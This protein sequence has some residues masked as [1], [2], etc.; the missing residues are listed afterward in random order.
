M[1]MSNNEC[2]A[3]QVGLMCLAR[4]SCKLAADPIKDLDPEDY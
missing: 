4:A 3:G 2:G 1:N